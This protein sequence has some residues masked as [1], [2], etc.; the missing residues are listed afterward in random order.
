MG[1]QKGAHEHVFFFI[2][3]IFNLL[4]CVLSPAFAPYKAFFKSTNVYFNPQKQ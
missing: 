2:S 4:C 3:F 1:A